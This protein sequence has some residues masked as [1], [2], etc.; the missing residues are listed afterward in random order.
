MVSSGSGR[1]RA[2]ASAILVLLCLLTAA[3]P[4]AR[5]QAAQR[6]QPPAPAAEPTTISV[7]AG[8]A[9]V[10]APAPTAGSSGGLGLASSSAGPDARRSTEGGAADD[11][12]AC[13]GGSG[14]EAPVDECVAVPDV[15]TTQLEDLVMRQQKAVLLEFWSPHCSKCR[16]VAP[17]FDL[18]AQALRGSAITVARISALTN[19]RF[20]RLNRVTK[21]PAF[22]LY[23]PGSMGASPFPQPYP[24]EP[25]RLMRMVNGLTGMRKLL[26]YDGPV[27][28][29][30]PVVYRDLVHNHD[31]VRVLAIAGGGAAADELEA[32]AEAVGRRL[33]HNPRVLVAVLD[34]AKHPRLAE[35]LGVEP[36]MS[37]FKVFPHRDARPV[38]TLNDLITGVRYE[39]GTSDVDQLVAV[40]LAQDRWCP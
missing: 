18:V 34:G 21:Y 40:V 35:S 17:D 8:G 24:L 7:T 4:S 1:R 16:D 39:G 30:K 13:D 37:V 6:P 32:T 27:L 12:A 33:R 29:L 2:V 22:M 3:P 28:R 10:P 11:G 5:A 14:S 20:F 19:K 23:Q 31:A 9:A 25:Q 38:P 15:S 36:G 26:P